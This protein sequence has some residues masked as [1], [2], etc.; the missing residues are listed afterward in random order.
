M[1]L[2]IPLRVSRLAHRP[3]SGVGPPFGVAAQ[4][5]CS[6]RRGVLRVRPF[7]RVGRRLDAQPHVGKSL[8]ASIHHHGWRGVQSQQGQIRGHL[9]HPSVERGTLVKPRPKVAEASHLTTRCN[10]GGWPGLVPCRGLVPYRL[11]ISLAGSS[12]RVGLSCRAAAARETAIS[13]SGVWHCFRHGLW[14]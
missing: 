11:T 1:F 6:Q 2:V 3:A 5:P 14:V 10:G 12:S 7:P 8:D 9:N 13:M 4:A